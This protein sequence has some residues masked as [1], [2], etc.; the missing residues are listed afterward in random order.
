[1]KE[2]PMPAQY[3]PVYAMAATDLNKDGKLDLVLAGNNSWTRIKF[4]QFKANH[5]Q[6]YMG[7]GKGN[8]TYL[9][10]PQSGLNIREDVRSLQLIRDGDMQVFIFGINNAALRQYTLR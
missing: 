7:D 10:Q 4:G 9:P 2:L 5:G 6:V 8:F 1:M 3:A